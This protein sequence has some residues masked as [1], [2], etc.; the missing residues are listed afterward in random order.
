MPEHDH[1]DP[2]QL[3][4][5]PGQQRQLVVDDHT[6]GVVAGIRPDPGPHG[7]ATM[8]AVIARRHR[9]PL[10]Q[11]RADEVEVA[12][13]VLAEAVDDLHDRLGLGDRRVQ[14]C[15]DGVATIGRREL[16]LLQCHGCPL[17]WMR[18]RSA[19]GASA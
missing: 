3:L 7:R 10:V 9:E 4:P 19:L 2:G 11:Q 6:G 16:D 12:P 5:H 13:R 1:R 17:R 18:R 8:P 15:L 14:P